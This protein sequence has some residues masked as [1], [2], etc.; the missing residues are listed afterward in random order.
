MKRPLK[1]FLQHYTTSFEKVY[2]YIFFRVGRNK[3]LAED[4]T[5]EVFLKAMEHF[6]SF[7]ES[8]LF[9]VWI[10]RIAHNHVVDFYK[11]AKMDTVDIEDVVNEV[12]TIPTFTNELNSKID[13]EKVGSA[14]EKLPPNQKDVM[15]MKYMHDLDNPQIAH[16]LQ[17]SEAHLR[18]LHHRALQA[19]KKQLSFFST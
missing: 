4:L 15:V 11:K 7:D 3:E 10:Y 14:L 1:T 18:V 19:L 2:R 17:I 9:L 5:S 16:I 6:D 13:L 8:K 12:K